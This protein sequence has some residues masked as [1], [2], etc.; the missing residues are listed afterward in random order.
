MG[1][2]AAAGQS[3]LLSN[4]R[5]LDHGHLA[6]WERGKRKKDGAGG[7]R[8]GQSS[9]WCVLRWPPRRVRGVELNDFLSTTTTAERRRRTEIMIPTRTTTTPATAAITVAVWYDDDMADAG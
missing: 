6:Q 3:K 7:W 2:T 9:P 1:V 8:L 5:S 4:A